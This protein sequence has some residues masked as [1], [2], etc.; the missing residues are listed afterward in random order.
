MS[1][2]LQK[3]IKDSAFAVQPG[4]YV[5][6]KVSD[7]PRLDDA[8]MLSR[9]NNETTAVFEVSKSDKFSIIEQNKDLRKLIEISVSAP[10]YAVGFLAAITRA[11]SAKGC[12]NLVVS[13]YS[14]D[15][16]L[17]TEAHFVQAKQALIE[18]GF[19]ANEDEK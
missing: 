19:S 10:F 8:F 16:I 15:Y 5:Y 4:R 1:P 17:V 14:K 11:I 2:E 12:N 18:L 7:A 6:A 13:T 3:V 9:D